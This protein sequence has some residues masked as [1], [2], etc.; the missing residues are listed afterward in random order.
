[1]TDPDST[2]QPDDFVVSHLLLAPRPLVWQVYTEAEHLK[3]WF[4]PPGAALSQC[5]M[6]LRPGGQFHYA[7]RFGAMP[8]GGGE[9]W[10]K[11]VFRAIQAPERL[12][13]VVSF[14]DAAGGLTRHPLNPVW[15]LETLGLTRFTEQGAQ[16][17]LTIHWRPIN[18]TAIE[19]SSFAAS[20]GLMQ[21]GWRASFERLDHYLAQ[22]P[23]NK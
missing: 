16:T 21:Q 8:S 7:M 14:S 9:Q 23:Q 22:L 17:L 20:H 6:D 2:P 3:G 4:G 5:Q 10:G 11:W 19:R 15:P 13:L 12:D 1:M 18:A